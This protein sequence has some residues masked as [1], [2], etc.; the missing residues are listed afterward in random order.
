VDVRVRPFE[1]R[2]YERLAAINSAVDPDSSSTPKSLRYRDATLE[3]RVRLLR[4]VAEAQSDQVVGA[5][6]VMHI[7]WAYHPRRYLLRI[8]VEPAWRRRGVG[9]ALFDHLLAELTAWGAELVRTE[10]PASRVESLKFLEHRGFHEWRRRWAPVLDVASAN[11]DPLLDAHQQVLDQG[12]VITTYAAEHAHA[13]NRLALDVFAADTLFGGDEPAAAGDDGSESMSFERFAAT[14]LDQPGAL[15]AGH[16][17]A[18]HDGLIVGISRLR[19][20]PKHA[21]VLHQ[22]LTGTHPAYRGRGIAKALKLCTIQF[23]REQGYRQI[24]T[25]NDATNAA[26]LHI[27]DAIGFERRTPTIIFERRIAPEPVP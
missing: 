26:M 23:A 2:D 18:L 24:R 27:N 6:Q 3:P 4:I 11:V 19:R 12:I 14:Q 25:S 10:A 13:G 8:E 9:T 5:G 15:A 16:F 20:D 1:D 22:E 7:W 21:D 17:L